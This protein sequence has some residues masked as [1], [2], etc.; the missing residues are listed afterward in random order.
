VEELLHGGG[1]DADGEEDA[2]EVTEE[3]HWVSEFSEIWKL[4]R[5][6]I[7]DSETAEESALH[8]HGLQKRKYKAETQRSLRIRK[9]EIREAT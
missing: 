9:E 1:G 2:A 3:E 6:H 7:R 5:Q 4:R 8:P